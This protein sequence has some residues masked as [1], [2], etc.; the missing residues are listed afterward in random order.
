MPM[1]SSVRALRQT[2][3][4]TGLPEGRPVF[5]QV[6][7]ANDVYNTR[8]DNYSVIAGTLQLMPPRVNGLM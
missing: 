7:F 8:F 1:R 4:K 2:L 3:K 5:P 6:P